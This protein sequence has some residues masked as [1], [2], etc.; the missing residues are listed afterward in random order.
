MPA[1]PLSADL[2]KSARGV[3]NPSND[4]RLALPRPAR[5]WARQQSFML[6]TQRLPRTQLARLDCAAAVAALAGLGLSLAHHV[7]S[8]FG[9]AWLAI[10]ALLWLSSLQ[11]GPGRAALVGWCFGLGVFGSGLFWLPQTLALNASLIDS[12]LLPALLIGVLALQPALVALLVREL[13]PRHPSATLLLAAPAAWT[14]LDALRHQ[15]SWAFP[16]MSLGYSQSA[17]SPLAGLAPVVGVLGTGFACVLLAGLVLLICLRGASDSAASSAQAAPLQPNWLDGRAAAGLAVAALLLVAGLSG[18]WQWTQADGEPTRLALLQGALD[19]SEKFTPEGARRAMQRYA[20]LLGQTQA[21]LVLLPETAVPVALAQ[22]PQLMHLLYA[23]AVRRDGQ[24]VVGTMDR[25]GA[26]LFNSAWI[27][28]A[29]GLQ[30]YRKRH[31]VPFGERFVGPRFVSERLRNAQAGANDT[32]AGP[33]NQWLTWLSGGRVAVAICYDDMFG[34]SLRADAAVGGWIA[35]LSNDGVVP[36]ASL[37]QQRAR[38]AQW[39]AMETQ[40]PI[41]RV[42]GSGYSGFIDATGRWQSRLPPAQAAVLE[43]SIQPRS[44]LTPYARFGD[45]AALTGAV[46]ALLLA[47]VS[48]GRCRVVGQSHREEA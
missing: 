26:D 25:L 32:S 44:G 17:A 21:P 40:R 12:H 46:A 10:A 2:A 23:T 11:R 39:R 29:D 4:A 22:A 7:D 20:E 9:L 30:T 27:I 41:A 18:R 48:A 33:N 43:G 13:Y 31:L 24:I 1:A 45:R 47:I 6:P 38:V 5:R 42:D 19:Q 34:D 14:L 8:A 37:R 16:W 35:L 3:A 28:G 36:V 15:T